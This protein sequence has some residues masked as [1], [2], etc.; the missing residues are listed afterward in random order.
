MKC[1]ICSKK[2]FK[3]V[4]NLG[5]QPWGNDFL[6]KKNL[7][8]EKLYP[9]KLV[10]CQSCEC[11]Q[12]DHT[13]KK[14]VMFKKHT[15]LSGTTKTLN[16][17][18][19]NVANKIDRYFF[20][21]RK[22]K[23]AFDIGSNDGTQLKHYKKIGYKVL[24]VESSS[25]ACQVANRNGIKT[26]N[27]FF[28]EKVAN[29]IKNK[30]DVINA[31]GVFFHLEELHSV[32]RGIKKLLKNDGVFV[33]QFIYLQ[34]MMK[35]LA[36]DQIYHEHLLYYNLKTI[37][38]LLNKHGLDL[39]HAYKSDIHGGSIIG[40]VCHKN[41]RAKTKSL[42]KLFEIEK[43]SKANSYSTLT[44]FA[45]KVKENKI[46]NNHIIKNWIKQ[47]KIIY[48]FGAPVKGNTLMNY[49]GINSSHFK[50]LVEKNPLRKG[51]YSPGSHIKIIL[52][53]EITQHPDIYYV[54]AWNFK[55]EI[56]KNNKYLIKKG[57]KFYF[58]INPK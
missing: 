50:Y 44:R 49:F 30:Y 28:N 56:L 24:G 10:Y 7:G 11:V 9:L 57:V 5:K 38:I 45:K 23:Y 37:E 47:K 15:Y 40:Y 29:N 55:K 31:S 51:L 16:N 43:K 20:K 2:K 27:S 39:F 53:N 41:F 58:P 25:T 6:Q 17:H 48:G 32:T 19:Q 22:N 26:L 54:L 3:H 46:K 36:F 1:I 34:E 21:K 35:N 4:L 52:E 33:V 14:E 42:T 13:V 8:K 18:F 12:L